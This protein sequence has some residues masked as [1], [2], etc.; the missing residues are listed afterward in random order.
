[1]ALV[2]P[3]YPKGDTGRPPVGLE[4]MLRIYFL[5][6]WFDLSDPAV[7]DA[8]YESL[9]MRRF[10]GVDPGSETAPDEREQTADCNS[11]NLHSHRLFPFFLKLVAWK[12]INCGRSG[13]RPKR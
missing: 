13:I 8:I 7:E 2:E 4:R 3:H 11:A 12:A 1:M 5:Q 6:Q 9:T 10:V